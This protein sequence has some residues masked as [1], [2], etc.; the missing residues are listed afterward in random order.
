MENCGGGGPPP[1]PPPHPISPIG[2][3]TA[4]LASRRRTLAAIENAC[5]TPPRRMRYGGCQCLPYLAG[6]RRQT[7]SHES[8]K[9]SRRTTSNVIHKA[10]V[11]MRSATVLGRRGTKRRSRQQ[12]RGV[13]RRQ[14]GILIVHD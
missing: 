6:I 9:P 14:W 1:P 5:M 4:S 8:A 3:R 13:K 12:A 2:A 7:L 10:D 11:L